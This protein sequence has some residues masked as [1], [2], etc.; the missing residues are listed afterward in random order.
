M[1]TSAW[2]ETS[3]YCHSR[4]SAAPAVKGFLA[5][6]ELN[7]AL[8]KMSTSL[9][10]ARRVS[11]QVELKANVEVKDKARQAR[12]ISR[13][14]C[15]RKVR[16]AKSAVH[17]SSSLFNENQRSSDFDP[18]P[19]GARERFDSEVWSARNTEQQI[20]L[21]RQQGEVHTPQA[22]PPSIP[23]LT[24]SSSFSAF[25]F[26]LSSPPTYPVLLSEL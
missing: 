7:V 23:N 5:P 19:F 13:L 9:S 6:L 14:L 4:L 26:S 17:R 12:A 22:A 21:L 16:I 15:R 10:I 8:R 2:W 24:W 3:S 18:S 25:P 11:C 1:F 20:T